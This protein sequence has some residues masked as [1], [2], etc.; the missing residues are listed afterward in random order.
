MRPDLANVAGL[1][2]LVGYQ[3]CLQAVHAQSDE[4]AHPCSQRRSLLSVCLL[5]LTDLETL[6][7]RKLLEIS[8][9]EATESQPT[10]TGG[11]VVTW[12]LSTR[13]STLRSSNCAW[14]LPVRPETSRK[15][16]CS[17]DCLHDSAKNC[18]A[19]KL[20]GYVSLQLWDMMHLTLSRL[21]VVFWS[22]ETIC[23]VDQTNTK[24]KLAPSSRGLLY[25]PSALR[26]PRPKPARPRSVSI[27]EHE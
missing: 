1:V 23:R 10:T 25:T 5:S 12:P 14:A 24:R 26:T 3:T 2:M 11:L 7:Q 20:G 16:I 22:G 6:P 19:R 17:A 9:S 4:A 15:A 8:Y 27:A 13:C 21:L 18:F